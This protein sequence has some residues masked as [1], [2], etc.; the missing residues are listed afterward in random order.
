MPKTDFLKVVEHDKLYYNTL[1]EALEYNIIKQDILGNKVA[2]ILA[3]QTKELI[4]DNIQ[5]LCDYAETKLKV[6]DFKGKLNIHKKLIE[7]KELHFENV[8]LP[9]FKK[10]SIE[11]KDNFKDTMNRA[12]EIKSNT[13]KEFASIV[14]KVTYEL[15]WWGKCDAQKKKNEE[16]IVQVYKPLKRLIS[17]YDKRVHEIEEEAKYK[18]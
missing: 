10:E 8:F 7:D 3:K 18:V 14:K 12:N 11:A 9:Q 16:Y 5:M 13:D 1:N 6:L 2:K 17:A 15:A 4:T